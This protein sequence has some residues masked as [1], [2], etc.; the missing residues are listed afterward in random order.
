M[1]AYLS[2]EWSI[3]ILWDMQNPDYEQQQFIDI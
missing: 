3:R 1:Y 2:A